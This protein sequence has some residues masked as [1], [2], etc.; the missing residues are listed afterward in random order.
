[1]HKINHVKT[2]KSELKVYN[3]AHIKKKTTI[4]KCTKQTAKLKVQL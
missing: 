4:T 2:N 1:M 3:K